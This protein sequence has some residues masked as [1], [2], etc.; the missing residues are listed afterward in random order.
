MHLNK[1]ESSNKFVRAISF[2]NSQEFKQDTKEEQ[3][4]A[5]ELSEMPSYAGITCIY[6]NKLLTKIP[7]KSIKSCLMQL[8]T[9]LW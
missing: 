6:E 1:V 8:K 7:L 4:I 3:V 2:G 5:E 9:A